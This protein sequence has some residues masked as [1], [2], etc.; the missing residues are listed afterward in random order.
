M[1]HAK[2]LKKMD[3]NSSTMKLYICIY[4]IDMYNIE[5]I[6]YYHLHENVSPQQSSGYFFLLVSRSFFLF[7]LLQYF[8]TE[9][10]QFFVL[11]F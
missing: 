9:I 7:D 4:C 6:C 3:M 10:G 5:I 2:K 8:L 1:N 11:T